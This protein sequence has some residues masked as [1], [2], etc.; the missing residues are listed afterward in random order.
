MIAKSAI[1]A[2]L[3]V[4]RPS[5][6]Q[7]IP[8][9]II[10]K[11]NLQPITPA[12]NLQWLSVFS[13]NKQPVPWTFRDTQDESLFLWSLI[14]HRGYLTSQPL[15]TSFPWINTQCAHPRP[16]QP[17]SQHQLGLSREGQRT[18]EEMTL[19]W[20]QHL[21]LQAM[22][23][24]WAHLT[25]LDSCRPRNCNHCHDRS[26]PTIRPLICFFL[27]NCKPVAFI[28]IKFPLLALYTWTCCNLQYWAC[29]LAHS[30]PW[31]LWSICIP[32]NCPQP[33]HW[34]ERI[35]GI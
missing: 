11:Y 28:P 1:S 6:S 13:L 20:V 10:L 33:G 32:D 2:L 21:F 12:L 24:L 25:F 27:I 29:P 4:F 35:K 9:W 23:A 34:K 18:A 8:F 26:S 15:L 16:P 17:S 3:K 31:Q 22:I 19:R 7:S 30:P 14:S 5:L